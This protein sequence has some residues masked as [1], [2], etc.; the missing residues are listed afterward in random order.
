M[1]KLLVKLQSPTVEVTVKAT[2]VAGN[3]SEILVGFKRYTVD[4]LKK[5]IDSITEMD[6]ST[7]DV[8]FFSKEIV[9]IKNAVLEV[10]DD[11]DNYLEDLVIKDTRTV[12]PN[13]FFQDSAEALTVLLG[14]YTQ[15]N[16]WKNALLA[17]YYNA[18]SN[19]PPEDLE[20]KN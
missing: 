6:S 2:D 4:E 12:E 20:L 11:N 13:E 15:S 9:Y 1:K 8:E 5:K 7:N 14:Y 3:S 17:G 19:L 18:L 10:Y 16:P